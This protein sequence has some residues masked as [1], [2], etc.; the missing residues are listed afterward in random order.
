MAGKGFPPFFDASLTVG[1]VQEIVTSWQQ[2]T[3][4]GFR[5][6]FSAGAGKGLKSFTAILD[7]LQ[8]ERRAADWRDATKARE[9][10]GDGFDEVFRYRRGSGHFVM[11]KDAA[12]ARHYRT[13]Q[14]SE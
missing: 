8:E 10:Y 6:R 1:H 7:D 4:A 12:I 11:S 2:L 13:L 9:E 14:Q 5:H 3:E